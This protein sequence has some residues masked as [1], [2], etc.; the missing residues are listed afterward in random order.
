M[1]ESPERRADARGSVHRRQPPRRTAAVLAGVLGVAAAAAR[2]QGHP[3]L[4]EYFDL[5]SPGDARVG[6]WLSP[7][8]RAAEVPAPVMTAAGA[9]PPAAFFDD[10]QGGLRNG[11]NVFEGDVTLDADTEREGVCRY[12]QVFEPSL[13]PWKRVVVRDRVRLE[14]GAPV[15]FV[16]RST[17]RSAPVGGAPAPDDQVLI[18]RVT[19]A[20]RGGDPVP[21]P[22]AA[23]GQRILSVR[24]QPVADVRLAVDPADQWFLVT[25]R[26]GTFEVELSVA[27][28]RSYGSGQLPNGAPRSRPV[29]P[30]L[31]ALVAPVAAA[32]GVRP[33]A[34]DV[35]VVVALSAWFREFVG[36][37]QDHAPAR[38]D[39]FEQ[40]AISQRG[41]CRHR[42]FAF[43]VTAQGLG[44]DAR[45][46]ANEAH[47]FVEVRLSD[48][49]WRRIDLGGDSEGFETIGDSAASDD[50]VAS[51]G[52]GDATGGDATAHGG[53]DGG[54]GA[55]GTGGRAAPGAPTSGDPTPS[56]T[57]ARADSE[58]PTSPP[59]SDQ[60]VAPGAL[61]VTLRGRGSGPLT[62]GSMLRVD[63]T[64]ST[65]AGTPAAGRSVSVYAQPTG[66]DDSMRVFIGSLTTDSAGVAG[67]DVLVPPSLAPGRWTFGVRYEGDDEVAAV[68]AE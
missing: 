52:G 67:G 64:L 14:G 33:G 27:V 48:G 28:P 18:E 20:A 24:S 57:S 65:A 4:H 17:P 25:D 68:E 35:D 31:A 26:S 3:V 6:G 40:I 56:A 49:L 2:A 12:M 63:A 23:P 47:A 9:L 38:V 66:A 16:E 41:V 54:A 21:I 34:T 32:A 8:A 43:V 42:A 51:A 60:E 5:P 59:A 13:A 10:D 7:G 1:Q 19:V 39:A 45:Y 22:S 36:A 11:A 15:L 55:A 58:L 29:E 30:A 44:V 61:T 53:A 62:R 37:A 50:A 46:V